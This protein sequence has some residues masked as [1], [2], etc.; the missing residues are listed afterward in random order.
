MDDFTAN[1]DNLDPGVQRL[2]G[3]LQALRKSISP[4]LAIRLNGWIRYG[5]ASQLLTAEDQIGY[6]ESALSLRG[7]AR[8]SNSYTKMLQGWSRSD[9]EL[10]D[11]SLDVFTDKAKLDRLWSLVSYIK[12]EDYALGRS[13]RWG[14][15]SEP[16]R[17]PTPSYY[18]SPLSYSSTPDVDETLLSEIRS[19]KPRGSHNKRKGGKGNR[20]P[21]R[22]PNPSF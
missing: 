10:F 3:R 11:G 15:Y 14:S 18:D 21:Q 7:T 20:K 1:T 9:A 16:S 19:I 5:T 6:L 17:W 22:A 2:L 4:H 8:K 12:E 13:S